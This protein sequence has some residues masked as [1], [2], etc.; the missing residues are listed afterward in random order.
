MSQGSSPLPML[1]CTEV[2]QQAVAVGHFL[3]RHLTARAAALPYKAAAPTVGHRGSYG[4]GAAIPSASPR[5]LKAVTDL[6]R[7]A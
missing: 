3:P 2:S 4:P 7:T 6:P 5:T 1:Q